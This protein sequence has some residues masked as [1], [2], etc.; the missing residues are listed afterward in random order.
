M[1]SKKA[2]AAERKRNHKAQKTRH[3]KHIKKLEEKGVLTQ[4]Q[5]RFAIALMETKKRGEAA[6][7]A[8]YSPKNPDQSANQALNAI[9]L[10]A[11]EAM[12][13]CGLHMKAVI[14]KHLVPLLHAEETRLAQNEGEYTDAIDLADNQVRLGATRMAF[15][16]LG[17]FK[18]ANEF[19]EKRTVDY[20]VVD[21]PTQKWP[22]EQL[23]PAA[24]STN[25]TKA[26]AVA[27]TKK[28]DPRPTD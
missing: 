2:K 4:K 15:E 26:P 24:A 16:L 10:K 28:K 19:S 21:M 5:S 17:A 13:E 23:E 7:I 12:A 27:P 25:G 8:G 20:I 22:E 11:P 1:A 18:Q 14:Q 9:L 6:L 3:Q